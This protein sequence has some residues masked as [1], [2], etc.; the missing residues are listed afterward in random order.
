VAVEGVPQ[1]NP[2]E[3]PQISPTELATASA[4]ATTNFFDLRI[5]DIRFL[6]CKS[7]ASGAAR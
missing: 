3:V 7:G 2:T 6:L 1:S 4:A 5:P